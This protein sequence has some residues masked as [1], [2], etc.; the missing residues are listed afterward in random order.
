LIAPASYRLSRERKS[1]MPDYSQTV[2]QHYG[3]A[4]LSARILD[5]LR[6][7]GK[8]PDNLTRDDLAVFDEFHTGGRASTRELARLAG[9]GR[10]MRVLDIGCGVGGPA[11][12][13]AAEFGCYVIGLDLTA[14]FCRAAAMLTSLVHLSDRVVFQQANALAL[15]FRDRQLDAAWSQNTIMNIE[16]KARLF[17]EIHRVLR[18][19]GVFALETVLS[20][21]VAEIHYPTFWASSP[22]MN[23]LIS[24]AHAQKL[25]A[26]AGFRE[27]LWEDITA[28]VLEQA[29]RRT[30]RPSAAAPTL[31]REV[32]VADDVARKAANSVRNHEENRIVSVRAVLRCPD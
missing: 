2:N 27:E 21:S 19:G 18:P 13:L 8:E 6:G 5:A 29:R 24:P 16:D 23:F 26:A 20:G 10:G 3:G 11:R 17:G 30:A 14:E 7:V 15:P 9:L 25:L 12:T 32:I 1:A 22:D 31:G 28:Q 4:D